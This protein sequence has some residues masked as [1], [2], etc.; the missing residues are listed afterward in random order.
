MLA[1]N[2]LQSQ[3]WKNETSSPHI[4]EK[5]MGSIG[6]AY[7]LVGLK[8]EQIGGKEEAFVEL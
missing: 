4:N 7:G 3:S 2:F 6:N 8:V 1:N 5:S